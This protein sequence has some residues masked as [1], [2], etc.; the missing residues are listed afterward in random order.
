MIALCC[1]VLMVFDDEPTPRPDAARGYQHLRHS[2]YLPPDFDQNVFDSLW[3]VWPEPLHSAA[4]KATPAERRK[5]AFDRYGLV[6]HPDDKVG[7]GLG[8]VPDGKGGWVMSCLACH[9][10]TVAG[11]PVPGSPNSNY[12]LQTL[13]EE[14]FRTKLRQLKLPSHLDS[15]SLD[16]PLGTTVGTTNA[17]RFGVILAAFREKSMDVNLKATPPRSAS[18]DMDAPPWW[19]MKYKKSLYADGFA[20]KNERI[21]LQFMMLPTNSGERM[22]GWEPDFR[23]IQAYIESLQPPKYPFEIDRKLA[24]KGRTIFSDNCARCHGS[25]EPDVKYEQLTVALEE[26]GTDPVRLREL[27]VE[28]REWVRDSWMSRFGADKTEVK[29]KGYV[30]PPL[31]GIWASAPYFHNGSVP[32]LWHVLHSEQ[33]P[34]VWKRTRDGYDQKHVGV[35]FRAFDQ[36]PESVTDK[37]EKRHYFDTTKFGKS[38]AGHTFPDELTKPEKRALLEYLKTL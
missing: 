18:M 13:T 6:A 15:V 26:I 4:Q 34:K 33:R 35:E 5:M 23:D 17:V 31:C 29:P 8:Y 37:A 25:Y 19:N 9:S 36:V 28:H 7:P 24:D 21:L 10:G 16:I 11:K 22:R 27:P 1:M 12:A 3:K 38:A 2:T 20:P 14:V 30:A 32:T